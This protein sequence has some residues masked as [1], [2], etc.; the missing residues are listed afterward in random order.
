MTRVVF[1]ALP[2]GGVETSA[3]F[4]APD[5]GRSFGYVPPDGTLHGL[6]ASE[7]K[8]LWWI[9]LDEF[10][11]VLHREPLPPLRQP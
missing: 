9:D 8:Q 10:G 3:Q 4:P 5:H 7:M 1:V 2:D 6:T 11:N